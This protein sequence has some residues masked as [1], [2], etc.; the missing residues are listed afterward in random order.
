MRK[1]NV[2]TL[3]YQN[4]YTFISESESEKDFIERSELMSI[5]I[6][7][8]L[9]ERLARVHALFPV[10][11]ITPIDKMNE[12]ILALVANI[13]MSRF[14]ENQPEIL[15]PLLLRLMQVNNA[16]LFHDYINAKTILP[17]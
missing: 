11:L 15:N 1:H 16:K 12:E 14:V 6:V 9:A 13:N 17:N 4:L 5:V 7:N 8:E 10:Q 3:E 2:D